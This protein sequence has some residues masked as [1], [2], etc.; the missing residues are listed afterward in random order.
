MA[1]ASQARA[2]GRVGSVV[3]GKYRVEAFLAA[4]T[5]ANVYAA[6]HRNGSRVALKILHKDLAADPA[7]SERFRR[8][9][10]FANSIGHPGIV[11]A[12]DDDETEDGCAFLV[13]E[14]LDGETLEEKR[15]RKGGRLPL[16]WVLGVADTL[17][18]ILAAAHARDVLHRDL[19]PDN[20]FVTKDGE[21]KV[22]DFGV[23]RWNDGKSSSDMT[24]VGMVLGTPAYMPPEQ[25]LGRRQ[26]VDAQSD[27]WGV[28]ATL[29]VV[30]SGET[31]HEGGDAKA[32]LIATART[33]ARS[34]VEVAPHV[35][36]AVAAV[37]DRALA[38][39][40]RDRW[41]DARAMR[42]ALRWARM[43]VEQDRRGEGAGSEGS[44]EAVPPPVPTRRTMEDEPTIT[45]AAPTQPDVLT[46]APP[47]TL[48]DVPPRLVP[49]DPSAHVAGVAGAISVNDPVFSLRRTKGEDEPLPS[50]QRLPGE[51]GDEGVE[52]GS[53]ATR[54][55]ADTAA[56]LASTYVAPNLSPAVRTLPGMGSPADAAEAGAGDAR[57]KDLSFT[58][59]MAALVMPDV[60][61]P[62]PAAGEPP[63]APQGSPEGFPFG[64]AP[65]ITSSP[66]PPAGGASAP[67][68]PQIPLAPAPPVQFSSAP[69]A[70]YAASSPPQ[71]VLH[72]SQPPDA[73][74]R[75]RTYSLPPDAPG[76]VLAQIVER[77][78]R[79][80][81]VLFSLLVLGL[82]A[83]A[84][85]FVL[86]RR[87]LQQMASAATRPVA[88][89]TA[90]ATPAGA[91]NPSA[92]P[93]AAATPASATTPA[94]AAPIDDAKLAAAGVV[95][96]ASASPS[97]VASDHKRPPAKPRRKPRP[98]AT[99]TTGA[100]AAPPPAGDPPTG[101]PTPP[102]TA[103]PSGPAPP[104][105]PEPPEPAPAPPPAPAAGGDTP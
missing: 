20:V 102:G 36:R 64:A 79:L 62:R 77:R 88:T 76:P 40:K 5:M 56:A 44:L 69:P 74:T 37:I 11:R 47:I 67:P 25:A 35:P 10:Y 8:E 2:H 45:R 75:G 32:K 18:D 41:P 31:V 24:G 28:G 23:A 58:R 92:S 21:V 29:F 51:S 6:T 100:T 65:R 17:L 83:G 95:A 53:R 52:E 48:R 99:S 80:P 104:A 33:P 90:S 14:L 30:L 86:R 12:I 63:P 105:P 39:D 49:A 13:M 26:D 3:R 94:S 42:E 71:G 82:A 16:H 96:T 7:L 60:P 46:S 85:V 50:T 103:G 66:P 22:L 84:I 38:F 34:L 93:S 87:A 72:V 19:K 98:P 70:A 81:R 4:G 68:P 59:P 9:G 55:S 89:E 57:G 91:A 101:D 54:P 73:L 1:D 27:L 15:R 78:S 61:A 97:A 43:S